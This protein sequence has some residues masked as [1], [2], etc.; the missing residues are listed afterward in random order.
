[1][2][3][4]EEIVK[5]RALVIQQKRELAEL[6]G[7]ETRNQYEIAVEGGGA[8]AY[9]AEQQFGVMGF[10]ARQLFGHWRK[11]D[12]SILDVSRNPLL[13][14]HHPFRWIFQRLEVSLAEGRP[15]GALQQRFALLSKRFDVE[16]ATGAVRMTVSSPLWR[17]W[18]FPFRKGSREVAVVTKKWGGLLTE[19]LLDKDRFRVEYQDTRLT[20]EERQ[21]ILAA[22]LFIDLQYFE[23][24]AG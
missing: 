10:L 15:I 4:A 18:T 22:A 14:A 17:I 5:Q 8:L 7:F 13:V 9:A 23:N 12:I 21:L 6:I 11:F 24:K 3:F 20:A 19:G 16:D 2:G 1:M